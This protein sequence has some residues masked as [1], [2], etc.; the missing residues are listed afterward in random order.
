MTKS[1]ENEEF[2]QDGIVR[3]G[4][5][6]AEIPKEGGS[7]K[8]MYS[9]VVAAI[10]ENMQHYEMKVFTGGLR[11][12]VW[13][14]RSCRFY[15]QAIRLLLRSDIPTNAA[16]AARARI[17]MISDTDRDPKNPV[18][19]VE[20][21]EKKLQDFFNL[22]AGKLTN[23]VDECV[24]FKPSGH[25]HWNTE[26]CNG[27]SMMEILTLYG[28]TPLDPVVPPK[29]PERAN[30]RSQPFILDEIKI[31]PKSKIYFNVT[32]NRSCSQLL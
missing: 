9:G 21:G 3:K 26:P 19:N 1:S 12:I 5:F 7:W 28:P 29:D 4:V 30:M 18:W 6:M 31:E 10:D 14:C 13:K 17:P 20:D 22:V 8:V 32:F 25:I 27:P 16:E 15:W 11:D 2:E 24:F 23:D